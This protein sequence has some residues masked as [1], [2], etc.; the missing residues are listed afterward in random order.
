M[1]L[2][3]RRERDRLV[4][5]DRQRVVGWGWQV[6]DVGSIVLVDG[7]RCR[8]TR[9]RM[10]WGE[11]RRATADEALRCGSEIVYPRRIVEFRVVA[12]PR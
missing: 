7:E 2:M 8:V 4:D 11:G 1:R 10:E 3:R 12:A 5:L 6:G 9:C